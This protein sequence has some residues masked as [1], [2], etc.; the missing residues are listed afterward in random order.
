MIGFSTSEMIVVIL[1][2]IL[3]L[4]PKEL[5]V[6]VKFIRNTIVK[7]RSFSSTLVAE[8]MNESVV[9]DIS[10]IAQDLNNELE[11]IIDLEG[12]PRVRYK[13]FD[14]NLKEKEDS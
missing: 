9:E 1:F 8:I 2:G 7:I 12:K 4:G 13:I 14:E 3:F 11:T 10:E 6:V 5:P